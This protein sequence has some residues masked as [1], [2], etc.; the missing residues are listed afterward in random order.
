MKLAKTLDIDFAFPTRTVHIED[1]SKKKASLVN[2]DNESTDLKEK[3]QAF[4]N[5]DTTV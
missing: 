2:F 3:L 5:E 4:L 1:F